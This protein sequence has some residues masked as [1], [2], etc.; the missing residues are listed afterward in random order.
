MSLTFYLNQLQNFN[1]WNYRS[2]QAAITA[3]FAEVKDLDDC[4]QSRTKV[5][6]ILSR[7]NVQV[8]KSVKHSF[9]LRR[10]CFEA[11]WNIVLEY[12]EQYVRHMD[13]LLH[14][15]F[16]DG[17]FTERNVK[18]RYDTLKNCARTALNIFGA[19][20]DRFRST[21]I[22]SIKV[23][24]QLLDSIDK[25]LKYDWDSLHASHDCETFP[26]LIR[27]NNGNDLP[28]IRLEEITQVI[29]LIIIIF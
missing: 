8:S 28:I 21:M 6:V 15:F 7:F 22:F 2:N 1:R 4:T 11:D 9:E 23:D 3:L 10:F 13:K 18:K 19:Y 17:I 20:G 29:K 14:Q 24:V 16:Q 27:L 26:D 5:M 25:I 12:S